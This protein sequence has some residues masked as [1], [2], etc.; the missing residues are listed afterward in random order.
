MEAFTSRVIKRV[1]KNGHVCYEIRNAGIERKIMEVFRDFEGASF[2]V[3]SG[4][5]SPL[6]KMVNENLKE[7]VVS[8]LANLMM[9]QKFEIKIAFRNM[10]PTTSRR[11]CWKTT[12]LVLKR[13]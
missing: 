3:T 6:L 8:L 7:A 12:S 1:Y 9:D 13:G 11:T 4:D 5:F 10:Q 2:Y